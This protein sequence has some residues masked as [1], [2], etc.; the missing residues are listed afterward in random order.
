M[1]E[2]IKQDSQRTWKNGNTENS[3]PLTN[4]IWIKKQTYIANFNNHIFI[5]IYKFHIVIAG[6][7]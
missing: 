3:V 5:T 2:K 1:R 6:I 4:N 7:T